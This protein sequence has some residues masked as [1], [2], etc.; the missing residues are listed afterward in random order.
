MSDSLGSTHKVVPNVYDCTKTNM[1][2]KIV[3]C[4]AMGNIHPDDL[5]KVEPVPNGFA[6]KGDYKLVGNRKAPHMSF[7]DIYYIN[8]DGTFYARGHTHTQEVYSWKKIKN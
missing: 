1:A 2:G 5:K 7:G 8:S 4:T 3:R 6:G